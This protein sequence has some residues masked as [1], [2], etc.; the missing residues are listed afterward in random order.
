MVKKNQS[1]DLAKK[2]KLIFALETPYTRV[3]WYTWDTSFLLV[4]D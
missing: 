2:P 3:K 1:E 4:V